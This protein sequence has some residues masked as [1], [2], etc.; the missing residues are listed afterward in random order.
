MNFK[1]ILVK[2]VVVVEVVVGPYVRFSSLVR[3]LHFEVI[4]A[5]SHTDRAHLDVD[6][7]LVRGCGCCCCC[8]FHCENKRCTTICF[9][10]RIHVAI[11]HFLRN[12]DVVVVVAFNV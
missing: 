2:V 12:I 4:N 9:E 8:C 11:N 1:S 10:L 6:L 7:A 3:S 5:H